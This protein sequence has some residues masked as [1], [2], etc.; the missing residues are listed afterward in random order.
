MPIYSFLSWLSLILFTN[1]SY[2]VYFHAVRDCY[3]GLFSQNEK[4]IHSLLFVRLAF[5]IYSFLSLCY[6]YLGGEGAIMAEIRGRYIQ[7]E[8]TKENK[9]LELNHFRCLDEAGGHVHVV[10]RIKNIQSVFYDFVNKY[11][12][13]I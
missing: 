1:D 10:Y 13:F 9:S 4:K 5:V 2:Y 7:Y 6:E 11:E 12:L 3:E 8:M